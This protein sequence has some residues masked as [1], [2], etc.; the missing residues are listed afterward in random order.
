MAMAN[1]LLNPKALLFFVVFLPQFVDQSRGQVALQLAILGATL[2][3][4]A[5]IFNSVLGALSGRVGAFLTQ[6]PKVAKYQG[7]LLGTVL[8]SLALR[9][10]LMEKPVQR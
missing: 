3:M 2:S 5:L 8:L 10:L 7:W 9:L 4:A 6:S 1:S